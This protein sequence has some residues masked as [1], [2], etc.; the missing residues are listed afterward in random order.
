MYAAHK[1]VTGAV[2]LWEQRVREA[3]KVGVSPLWEGEVG[4]VPEV[5]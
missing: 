1:N 4:D 2:E 5:A 3:R